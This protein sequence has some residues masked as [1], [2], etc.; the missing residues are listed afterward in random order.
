MSQYVTET[1]SAKQEKALVALIAA[2]TLEAAAEVAKV[3]P[4]TLHRWIRGD[5]LF[6]N[7]YKEA[8]RAALDGAIASLQLGAT[9]AVETLREGMKDRNVQARIRAASIL[10]DNAFKAHHAF[11]LEER[12]KRLEENAGDG[13]STC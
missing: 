7:E 1:L 4:R 11:D 12:L 13:W 6:R 2:P 10:L 3:T 8:R 9:E 5:R